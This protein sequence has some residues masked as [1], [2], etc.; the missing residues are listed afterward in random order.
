MSHELRRQMIDV[1]DAPA[2]LSA[3]DAYLYAHQG[4]LAALVLDHLELYRHLRER[5]EREGIS[6]DSQR[7]ALDAANDLG[8]VLQNLRRR[9]DLVDGAAAGGI[10]VPV[11]IVDGL[12]FSLC[13]LCEPETPVDLDAPYTHEQLEYVYYTEGTTLG[14]LRR[15]GADVPHVE[16]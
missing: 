5:I 13:M 15:L 1:G 4:S 9:Q 7:I 10:P 16:P 6:P 8:L 3:D 2:E 14:W 12:F 11:D